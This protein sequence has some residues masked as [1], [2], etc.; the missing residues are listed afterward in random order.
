M[1]KSYALNADIREGTGKGSSRSL[2]RDNKV[3]AVIYGDKK[4]PVNIVISA[5]DANLEYQTGQMFTTICDVTVDGDKHQVLARDVQLHPVKDTVQHID[6]LRVTAKT[7]IAVNVPVVFLNEEQC[8]G[9]QEK[10]TLSVIRYDVEL[11]CQATNIPDNIEVD[12]TSFEIGD[13]IKISHVQLPE[14]AK[15]VIDD[16]DFTIASIVA[17]RTAEEMDALD[18]EIV[19][20]LA[21]EGEGEEGSEA[22]EGEGGDEEGAEASEGGDDAAEKSE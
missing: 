3:P 19:D 13:A 17:P 10:G 8:L 9:I 12:L 6:F 1:A 14:G 7:Q 21:E 22:S 11:V 5:K 2:R 16:R 4:A 20:D 18:D 15:P